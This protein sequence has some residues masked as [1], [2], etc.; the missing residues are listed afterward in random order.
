LIMVM[1]MITRVFFGYLSLKSYCLV[2]LHLSL[3]GCPTPPY[4]LEGRVTCGVLIGLR[5]FYYK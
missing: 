3:L 2:C 4:K 5:L 1:L